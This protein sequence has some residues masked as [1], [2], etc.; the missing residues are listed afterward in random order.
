V[1]RRRAI[2]L[3]RGEGSFPRRPRAVSDKASSKLMWKDPIMTSDAR[4]MLVLPSSA[5]LEQFNNILKILVGMGLAF[6]IGHFLEH[7]VQFAVWSGGKSQWVAANFCGRDTPYMSRPV[8]EMVE[9][10]G[11]YLFP[12]ATVARQMMMGIEILHLI[13]NC[14]FL[15]TIA[16]VYY[17]IPVK[18]VRYALYIEG[19]HMCEHIAL[20]LSAYY[21]GK[22]IGLSTMFGQASL[23]WGQELAVGWRVS[24]HFVM[25]L[26]PL[27]FVMMAMMRHFAP[28]ADSRSVTV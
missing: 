22:P 3:R 24:W 15:A 23:W 21:L 27:P 4:E 17:F 19:A 20:T 13:G 26:L 11:A 10:L 5:G 9:L 8:T 14:I 7:A 16:G 25:N 12:T 2:S 6:Q 28:R 18:L 1:N